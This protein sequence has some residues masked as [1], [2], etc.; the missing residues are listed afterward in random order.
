MYALGRNRRISHVGQALP[1]LTFAMLPFAPILPFRGQE[2]SAGSQ[3]GSELFFALM[4]VDR[5]IA[6]ALPACRRASFFAAVG[7]C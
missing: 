4:L 6:L 2:T 5:R 3:K 7:L 1:C